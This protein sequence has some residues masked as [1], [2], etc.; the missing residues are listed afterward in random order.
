[1]LGA[2]GFICFEGF[3]LHLTKGIPY[4]GLAL[5]GCIGSDIF[6]RCWADSF[7][8]RNG[9]ARRTAPRPNLLVFAPHSHGTTQR[10][11]AQQPRRPPPAVAAGDLVRAAM[12]FTG[13]DTAFS[14]RLGS[15]TSSLAPLRPPP[16][17]TLTDIYALSRSPAS[18]LRRMPAV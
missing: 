10:C 2:C 7:I 18:L 14:R 6:L 13:L 9:A 8:E 15:L 17:Y 16:C 1:M 11:S 12:R 3:F 4:L 5:M